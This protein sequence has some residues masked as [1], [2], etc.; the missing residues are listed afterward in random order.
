MKIKNLSSYILFQKITTPKNFQEN[1]NYYM[2]SC[3]GIGHTFFQS[4]VFRPQIKDKKIENLYYVGASIH[5]GNG[6]SI[7]MDCAK[8]VANTINNEK[9]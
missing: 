4:M 5:P 8:I 7:V 3:F 9:R 6:A 2:G 1:F